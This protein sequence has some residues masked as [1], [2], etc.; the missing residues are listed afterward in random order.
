MP[1]Q[2]RGVF[3]AELHAV[4]PGNQQA[5]ASA[6]AADV[7]LGLED[8]AGRAPVRLHLPGAGGG[9][10]RYCNDFFDSGHKLSHFQLFFDELAGGGWQLVQPVDPQQFVAVRSSLPCGL[11]A[12]VKAP[13]AVDGDCGKEGVFM[14]FSC[15]A[16]ITGCPQGGRGAAGCCR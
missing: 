3:D 10:A 5:G 6:Q 11:R 9:E 4:A 1:V 14:A 13:E 7:F 8:E 15:S 16:V 12:K 2:R